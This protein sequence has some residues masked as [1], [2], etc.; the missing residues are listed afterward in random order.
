MEGNMKRSKNTI[1]NKTGLKNQKHLAGVKAKMVR[2]FIKD[3]HEEDGME[4]MGCGGA[5]LE[6][7]YK[8]QQQIDAMNQMYGD[9]TQKGHYVSEHN[10]IEDINICAISQDGSKVDFM[11]ISFFDDIILDAVL[12]KLIEKDGI[13][14]T[15]GQVNVKDVYN[16]KVCKAVHKAV[17][18]LIQVDKLLYGKNGGITK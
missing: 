13:E 17:N 1:N 7:D 11:G 2:A 16:Q 9:Q 4:I 12:K 10:C 3:G 6:F 18:D 15:I 14:L 5:L 8:N